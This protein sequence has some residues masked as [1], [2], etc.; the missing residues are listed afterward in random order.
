[1]AKLREVYETIIA[2]FVLA[3]IFVIL[4]FLM[5]YMLLQYIGG[6][7]FLIYPVMFIVPF[8]T[9]GANKA[10]DNGQSFALTFG[11]TLISL[12]AML[13]IWIF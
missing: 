4:P 9:M 5:P 7:T 2:G 11:M 3:V 8:I 6:W 12:I 10:K 1:M 13:L